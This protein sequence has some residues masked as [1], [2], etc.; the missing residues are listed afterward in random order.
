MLLPKKFL[1]VTALFI[2]LGGCGSPPEEN[3]YEL[4]LLREIQA[5]LAELRAENSE[6]RESNALLVQSVEDLRQLNE[7]AAD[8]GTPE[9]V[10]APEPAPVANEPIVVEI[11]VIE[12]SP[13]PSPI[14]SPTPEPATLYGRW[15]TIGA[16][17]NGVAIAVPSEQSFEMEF[18][19]NGTGTMVIE[20][21]GSAFTW[22]GGDT[23]EIGRLVITFTEH[24][25][26][27]ST[28]ETM[29]YAITGTNMGLTHNMFDSLMT[30]TMRKAG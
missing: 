3:N 23:G 30:T 20:G 17:Q 14:P 11:H 4:E 6:L 29:T 9:E 27:G 28:T 7:A 18:N 12:P 2:M 16:V 15:V 19:S 22:T 25:G 24:F 8:D 21:I 26:Y 1:F 5:E 13:E 10:P